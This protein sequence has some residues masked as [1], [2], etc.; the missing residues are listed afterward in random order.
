MSTAV[1]MQKVDKQILCNGLV[2]RSRENDIQ[3]LARQLPMTKTEGLLEAVFSVGSAPR[4][5]NKDTSLAVVNC[6]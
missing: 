6:Q 4:L 3:S 1:A 2:T 5:Y